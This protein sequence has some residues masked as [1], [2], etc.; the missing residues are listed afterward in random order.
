VQVQNG[1]VYN[2][3][4]E[5]LGGVMGVRGDASRIANN[6]IDNGDGTV[7]DTSTGL[8]WQQSGPDETKNWQQALDYCE[9]LSYAGYSDWRLPNISELQSIIDY[10]H[11]GPGID[12]EFFPYTVSGSYYSSTTIA[13]R[14]KKAWVINFDLGFLDYYFNTG[15]TT[16]YNVRAVRGGLCGDDGDND[17]DTLCNDAD[18]CPDA[19]NPDQADED[20]D[21]TGDACET[22]LIQLTSF[23]V[24][25]GSKKTVVTWATSSEIANEGFNLYRAEAAEGEYIKINKSRIPSQGTPT[26]GWLYE[27]VDSNVK[28]RTK[29][30]YKLE[31]I[32]INGKATMHGPGSAVPRL[33][34]GLMK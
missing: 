25:P 17:G 8:M 11:Y 27:F 32:D 34:Y 26:Q 30:Y 22:T 3:W 23:T 9:T 2:Y 24:A 16:L 29:Y 28:N 15:K 33:L 4:H 14:P 31:D 21:G 18:N 7:S 10:T 5:N 19:F 1:Y 20:E 6:F 13:D 12:E